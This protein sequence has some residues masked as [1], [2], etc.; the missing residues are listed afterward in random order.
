MSEIESKEITFGELMGMIFRHKILL[1]IL[2]LAI[3]VCGT[4]AL[5]LFSKDKMQ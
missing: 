2:T 1:L 3:T 5:T 4:L